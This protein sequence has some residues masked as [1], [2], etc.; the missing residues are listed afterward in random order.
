VTTFVLV[1]S[2]LMGPA[3]WSGV[4]RLL[5]E[6]GHVSV[7]PSLLDATAAGPPFASAQAAAVVDA[8]HAAGVGEA[9]V[10]VGHSGAGPLLPAAGAELGEGVAS[11]LFVD[12]GL[13]TPGRPR[14]QTLHPSFHGRLLGMARN[15]VLPPW[16]EWWGDKAVDGLIA[17]D[18]VRLRVLAELRPVPM[19]LFTEPLPEVPSWP[20][21][22][23]AYLR[24]SAAYA[25]EEAAA[26]GRG[27]PVTRVDGTHLE[28]LV[29][30]DTVVRAMLRLLD[31]LAL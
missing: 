31:R 28:P 12:A 22:P 29:R 25:G 3:T 1:H 4:A 26:A 14:A 10:L 19:A 23:C 27:W 13:P 2:P 24:C 30:P 6:R 8:V 7:V 16:S 5:E 20:D 21:R 15:G 17:D 11:Y 9:V 18:D